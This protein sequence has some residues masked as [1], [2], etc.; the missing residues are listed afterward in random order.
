M[1]LHAGLRRLVSVATAG[2]LPVA[3]TLLCVSVATEQ[4]RCASPRL[5]L[6]VAAPGQGR[7]APRGRSLLRSCLAAHSLPPRPPA[8][9][10]AAPRSLAES[11][12]APAARPA[13]NCLASHSRAPRTPL[14]APPFRFGH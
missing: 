12:I 4:R 7:C 9:A 13:A 5:S 2:A 10:L 6:H 14:R 1:F 3:R 11:P 8:Y